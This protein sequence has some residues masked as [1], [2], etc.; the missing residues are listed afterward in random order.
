MAV[1]RR[2]VSAGLA[3]ASALVAAVAARVVLLGFLEATS[4]PSNNMLYLLPVVPMALA[5]LPMV[6]FGIIA[7][8]KK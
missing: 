4:I 6:L 2:R 7:S 1:R 5:L 3:V 8:L